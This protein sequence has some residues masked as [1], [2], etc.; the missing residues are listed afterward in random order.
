MLETTTLRIDGMSCALCSL[1]I[2]RALLALPGVESAAVS[3]ASDRAAIRFASD[4]VRPAEFARA[5]ERLGFEASDPA[6]GP[7]SADPEG[8]RIRRLRRAL[9]WAAALSFPLFFM[10]LITG[11]QGCHAAFDP[12]TQS[13]WGKLSVDLS[14]RF[15]FLHDWRF[16]LALVTPV[17]FIIG[18]GFYRNAWRSLRLGVPTMDLL[19][20]IGSLA[21]YAYSLYTALDQSWSVYNHPKLYFE[22][23]STIVTLVLLGKYLEA[24]ARRRS[25]SAVEA[26][27]RLAPPTAVLVEGAEER[28]VPVASLKEGDELIVRPGS[29]VP[30]DGLVVSGVSTLD[31]S[32][33]TGESRPIEKEAGSEVLAGTMNG[34]GA[35]RVQAARV[36]EG[37]RLAGILRFVE[38]AQASKARAQLLVD[39]ICSYFVPGVLLVAAGTFLCWFLFA[40]KAHLLLVDQALVKAISV[41]VVSCPCALG[42]ATP[43]ALVAGMGAAARRGIL[44]KDGLAIEALAAASLA[45]FDK[46]GTITEGRPSLALILPFGSMDEDEALRVAAAAELG[47]EHPFGRAFRE[48]LGS[49]AALLPE[50]EYF[51]SQPGKGVEA[52]VEGRVV[53]VGRPRFLAERGVALEEAEREIDGLRETGRSVVALAADGRL[54]ALFALADAPRPEAAEVV[55]QLASKGLRS[56]IVSGDDLAAV[57]LAAKAVGISRVEAPLSPEGKAE[58]VRSLEAA[59]GVVAMIGDGVNDAPALAAARV[60]VALGSGADVAIET[61]DVVILGRDLR[62]LPIAFEIARRTVGRVK[63]NLAWAFGYNA[64]CISFAAAGALSPELA[65]LAMAA[66]SLTVLLGSLGIGRSLPE[67]SPP[68][69]ELG[70]RAA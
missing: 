50:P 60:G 37:T 65:A 67:L 43:A 68:P 33:V 40:Y 26:L 56:I 51:A 27:A 61:G 38:E 66:S 70:E 49:R 14:Y 3:Y 46:T 63:A 44:F 4:R 62:A 59:G 29:R 42:L 52:V 58:L 24:L 54:E 2:E 23:G 11:F 9:V 32:T 55:E 25:R 47:S 17:Q 41:L 28:E 22:A 53:L 12:L 31:E 39:R 15:L 18:R 30:V 16:Q 5:V 13:G 48:A 35:L 19:V 64:I 7:S 10:M 8:R 34:S 6:S 21:S 57:E 69:T 45:A 36:G 20:A 1:E